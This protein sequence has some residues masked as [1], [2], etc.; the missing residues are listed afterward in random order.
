MKDKYSNCDI[1]M[2]EY[3]QL[4]NLQQNQQQQQQSTAT[5]AKSTAT[6]AK[7]YTCFKSI[8]SKIITKYKKFKYY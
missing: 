5:A 6:A 4:V 1:Y 3:T 2:I 8:Y 7:L